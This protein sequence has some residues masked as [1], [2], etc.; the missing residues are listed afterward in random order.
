MRLTYK[1]LLFEVIDVAGDNV[2][3]K[4]IV[5]LDDLGVFGSILEVDVIVILLNMAFVNG[6]KIIIQKKMVLHIIIIILYM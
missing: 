6:L 1:T 4:E 2:F 3:T 5:Y